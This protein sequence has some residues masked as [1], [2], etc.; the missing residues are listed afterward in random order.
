MRRIVLVVWG[1]AVSAQIS[2][3]SDFKTD[4]LKLCDTACAELNKEVSPFGDRNSV[5]AGTH[6][7]PFFEDS[8]AVRALSVA[9][10][11]TGKKDYLQTCRRWSDRI[12]GLQAKMI[13]NG[14]YYLNY[15]RE[16]GRDKGEWYVAD[17]GCV[18]M[19]V[20]AT[21]VRCTNN[22]DRD[23]YLNSVKSF[24]KLVIDNY[25]GKEGGVTDGLWSGY[26]GQWWCSTA[27]FGSLMFLLHGETGNEQYLKV[28]SGAMNWMTRHDFHKAEHISFQESAPGVVFY[29]F[30]FYAT[31]IDHLA[32]GTE[33]RKAAMAQIAEAVRW[34][35]ENQRGR[36]AKSRWDYFNDATYM[37]GMPYLM[38]VFARHLPEHRD[39]SSAADQELRYIAGLLSNDV[40]LPI[41]H[42]TT[43]E[44]TTWAM[45]SY[46][47][48]LNPGALHRRSRS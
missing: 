9:Y 30:E 27:T 6:H 3:A 34:M 41:A 33:T 1:L 14:A 19:G 25:V 42:V 43:W 21:A 13:P 11:M 16:S 5:D 20:L 38:Y 4:F 44:L 17:A 32:P 12:I 47:E 18:A 35:A 26:A 39:L 7:V 37:S 23:R 8:Y 31:G 24:A 45:M 15:G 46:A 10:D 40:K 28:A 29:V 36:G 48:K 2:W 22:A